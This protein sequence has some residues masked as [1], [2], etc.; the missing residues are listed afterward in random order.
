MGRSVARLVAMAVTVTLAPAA[1]ARADAT[2]PAW[3]PT[4][5]LVTARDYATATLLNNGKVLVAGGISA[6]GTGSGGYLAGAELYDPATGV[7]AAPGRMLHS[8]EYHTATLLRNGQVLVTGGYGAGGFQTGAELYDPAT[9]KWR[10]TGKMP[11]PR[12]W[13][14]ATLL[15]SGKVLIAGGDDDGTALARADLYDP[16][17]G[18][19]SRAGS[20]GGARYLHSAT[21]LADGRVLVAGGYNGGALA[22]ARLYDPKTGKWSSTGGMAGRRSRHTATLLADGRVLVAGGAR[23]TSARSP[24]A[25]AELYD[26]A[27]GRWAVARSL[28]AARFLHTATRLADGTVLVTGGY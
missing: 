9:G 8:R 10:A 13:H 19:W 27:T 20:M 2:F 18:K 22:T 17:T 21:R 28:G 6:K 7:W 3:L 12:D 23:N 4:G 15:R 14:T 24:L 16:R 5:G 1:V 25:T 11:V 26:P